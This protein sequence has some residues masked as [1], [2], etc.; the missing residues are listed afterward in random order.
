VVYFKHFSIDD[1]D[2]GVKLLYGVNYD[3]AKAV[4]LSHALPAINIAGIA[5]VPA[6]VVTVIAY[7]IVTG[8]AVKETNSSAG[9]VRCLPYTLRAYPRRVATGKRHVDFTN[10]ADL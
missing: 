7:A 10:R 2:K 1:F 4:F 9:F 8:I 5:I 6:A 3:S